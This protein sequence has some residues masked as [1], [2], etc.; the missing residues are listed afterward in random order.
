MK[1]VHL[2]KLDSSINSLIDSIRIFDNS[3]FHTNTNNLKKLEK[4]VDILTTQKN[5]PSNSRHNNI[6]NFMKEKEIRSSN[7]RLNEIFNNLYQEGYNNK[8]NLKKL[9]Q[10]NTNNRFSSKYNSY[11]INANHSN[12]LENQV[13]AEFEERSKKKKSHI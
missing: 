13:S 8:S 12:T 4:E 9:V 1:R 5:K 11:K 6:K 2:I 3:S 10:T 7:D